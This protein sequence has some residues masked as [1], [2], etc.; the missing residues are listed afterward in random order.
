MSMAPY[1]TVTLGP[2]DLEL[3]PLAGGGFHLRSP[4]PLDSYPTTLT[5]R[6][7]ETA[8]RDPDRLMIAQ[9]V[10]GGA[11]EGDWRK[12]SYA[13][14]L[15][16]V[17]R[18]GQALLDRGLNAE[19]PIAIL[20]GSSI[21]HALLA[22]AA[23]HV[24]I[25]Y[26]SVTPNYSLLSP[27]LA[28]LK[29]VMSL[30]TPGLVFAADGTAFEHAL[31]NGVPP[32]CELMVAENAPADRKA[33]RF[34]D[35]LTAPAGPAV[36]AA[37]RAITT[38]SIARFLF[39]SGSTGFPKAVIYTHGMVCANQQMFLQAMPLMAEP[40]PVLVDWLPWHHT[41]GG[42]LILG[43]ILYNGGTIYIDE[44]KPVP[45]AFEETVRNLREIAPT[46]YFTVPRGYAELVYRLRADEALRRTFF[47][48]VNML[49][50]SG[51]ALP[52]D[53]IDSLDELA[54]A[55]CGERIPI[56]SGYGSTET[57]AF[58]TAA[59]WP[60]SA[61]GAAGLPIPGSEMKL[62]P[63]G[64]K[65]EARFRSPCVTP[66][67]WRQ[68]ELTNK[69]FDEEGYYCMGDALTFIDPKDPAQGLI[70]DGRVAEDFKLS[71]GTWVDV[72][73][74]RTRLLAECAPLA[75]DIVLAGENRDEITALIFPNLAECR[76]LAGLAANASAAAILAAPVVR[77][78]FQQHLDSFAATAT[79]SS[80]RVVRAVLL[81]EAASAA[82]GELT[83]KGSINAKV[84]LSHR[85]SLVEALYAAQ[86]STE[87]IV[88]GNL[89]PAT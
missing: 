87:V 43:L 5:D 48:R 75:I 10:G 57:S 47:S 30:L 23:M 24:G 28:K 76:P 49:Y 39:T 13:E 63:S 58:V 53:V 19:R 82:V 44:G 66:G 9:R 85:K 2:R 17:E 60:G 4:H 78:L 83:D 32:G 35:L 45:G 62:V 34:A 7:V 22:F 54:V 69:A 51:A 41:S 15:S 74:L 56:V 11:R 25:P 1:R 14:V 3:E 89:Q 72:T 55:A 80:N 38:D 42:N 29:H 31:R 68:P 18:I 73:G 65:L 50:Y 86:P 52:Q 20:S 26:V 88:A 12:L 79:G 21:E 33:T 8:R 70:F 36:A 64:A 16:A 6:L 59:N 67:Y 37:H 40:A 71:T 84:V 61:S 27:D 81:V 46:L 77:A